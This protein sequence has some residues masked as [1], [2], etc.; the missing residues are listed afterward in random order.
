[1]CHHRFVTV[2]VFCLLQRC[3]VAPD[4]GQDGIGVKVARNI[5]HCGDIV[6]ESKYSDLL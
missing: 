5:Q 4:Y 3:A 1:M 2:V 6:I